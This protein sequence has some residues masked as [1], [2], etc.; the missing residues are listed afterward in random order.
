MTKRNQDIALIAI[1]TILILGTAGCAVVAAWM[2]LILN[3]HIYDLDS[4]MRVVCLAVGIATLIV[5]AVWVRFVRNE[6]SN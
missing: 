4:D 5:I 6:N 3:G 1:G 2:A